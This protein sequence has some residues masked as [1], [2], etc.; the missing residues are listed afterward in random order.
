[1][2]ALADFAVLIG[3]VHIDSVHIRILRI[4]KYIGI[5]V[6]HIGKLNIGIV[7]ISSNCAN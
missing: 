4:A 7:L 5:G 3:N 1:M 6:K 2:F